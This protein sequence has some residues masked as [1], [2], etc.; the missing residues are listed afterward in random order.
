MLK[1]IAEAHGGPT[2]FKGGKAFGVG[3]QVPQKPAPTV[4]AFP[5]G[6]VRLINND[7]FTCHARCIL[8]TY[9]INFRNAQAPSGC[10]PQVKPLEQRRKKSSKRTRSR[11]DEGTGN[12]VARKVHAAVLR[13]AAGGPPQDV[14]GYDE[15]MR[16]FAWKIAWG[17]FA[18][19]IGVA[20]LMAV[21]GWAEAT[22]PSL[23][24]ASLIPLFAGIAVG[25]GL[26]V[27]AAFQHTEFQRSHPF[28]QDFYT[29]EDR[30]RTQR[31]FAWLLVAGIALVFT[32]IV[33][34]ALTDS[35]S[36]FVQTEAAALMMG[37]I[38]VGVW[39]IVY[40]SM[41]LG[42]LN[43]A[44]YNDAREQAIAESDEGKVIVNSDAAALRAMY[45]DEQICALL[46]VP[47]AS[48]EEIER[49]RARIERK[50]R[51]DQLTSGLCACIMIVATI[52][53]LVMLFVPEYETPYFWLAWAIGGLLCAVAAI[54][55]GSFV[56]DQPSR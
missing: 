32:G 19:L 14:C 1:V 4:V 9:G 33:L 11:A 39:C 16:T 24:G 23:A 45:T 27:T 17:V 42:R 20:L 46:G 50:R 2:F 41:M 18:I 30:Q 44:N 55:V 37:L 5:K 25:L 6:Q 52:A 40:G 54:A 28:I 51:K 8:P 21:A 26:I 49:A 31:L 35:L 38:A 12:N 15:H 56:K 47:E 13:E 48:D 53:G 7:H 3:S 22:A 43:I 10:K 34:T 29:V 36:E